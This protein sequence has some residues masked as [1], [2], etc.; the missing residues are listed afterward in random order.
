MRR[1]SSLISIFIRFLWMKWRSIFIR[2]MWATIVSDLR[3]SCDL[4]TWNSIT[5]IRKWRWRR[6]KIPIL[7]F[8]VIVIGPFL[9]LG[10]FGSSLAWLFPK[11][12][13]PNRKINLLFIW[14]WSEFLLINSKNENRF[15]IINKFM[16]ILKKNQQI[17][18]EVS[19]K[20]IKR[21]FFN[22]NI[23]LSFIKY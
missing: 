8:I 6:L 2:F 16:V 5:H 23:F 22:L 18:K 19:K 7:V 15:K 9:I 10:K 1:K 17:L 13:K 3:C 14:N 12:P 4:I 11:H 21:G 20:K